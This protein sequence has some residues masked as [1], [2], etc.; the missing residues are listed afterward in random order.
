MSREEIKV[1]YEQG[2]DAVMTLVEELI[3]TFQQQIEELRAQVKELHD[4]LALD[5]RNSS[6]PPSSNPPAQRTKSLRAPSGK[7]PGAQPGHPGT[8]LKAGPRP[9]RI[10]VHAAATCHD[11]GHSLREVGGQQSGDR[12]QVF[13]LPLLKLEVTE[14]RL[15][16]K[17]G[18]WCGALTGGEFPAGIAPGVQYGPQLKAL[19]VY[20]V[21]YHLLPWQRTCEMLSDLFGHPLA[22]GTLASA[23]TECATF[24][25]ESE[26]EIKQALTQAPVA[27]FDETGLYVAGHREWVH[28]A[29]TPLLTH[30]GP[31]AKRGAE[32]T[33]AIGILPAF[34]GRAMHDTWA[35]YFDYSCAHGLC[36]AHHLRE[37]TFVH[38]QMG[39]GWAK[40]MKDV[41]VTIKHAVEH[42]REGGAT[43]LPKAQQRR[44]EKTYDHLLATGL[45][46]P[47]NHPLPSN[48]KRGRR[49]QS[50]A[51][52]LLARL[53]RRKGETLAFM[54]D[55]TVPFDN[56]QAERDLRM[57]KVQQKVS[58]CFRSRDGAKVFCRIRGYLSTL[59]KQG[60]NVL[61]ALSNVFA[62]QP[63]SPLPEG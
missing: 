25:E 22:G 63:L 55:F 37:L 46:M 13:D 3:A 54:S 20:W 24:L 18:L 17:E 9:E 29:S 35:P 7:K 51:K 11:C 50:K 45:Q 19:A 5:S 32:A 42:A 4:R 49:K 38:E 59:K 23:L 14:H 60:R 31:H 39:Q 16:E 30:Y 61:A 62:G 44:F 56:N 41:L 1:R 27:T 28:V 47:A 34:T 36:N 33:Q 2:P 8:T 53:A 26:E 40:E 6:K 15:L 43:T 10:V 48:G 58:G 12:R 52:N 57:V 21:Q